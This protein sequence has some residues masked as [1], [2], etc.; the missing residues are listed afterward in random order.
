MIKIRYPIKI[1][2]KLIVIKLSSLAVTTTEGQVHLEQ[3]EEVARD[4]MTLV[5]QL[6]L[7]VILVSSGAVNAG[8]KSLKKLSSFEISNLQASSSIGQPLLMQAFQEAFSKYQ[9][10]TAQLLLTHD[11]LKSK[12]RSYNI[13]S[14][15]EALLNNDLIPIINENDAVSFDEITVGDNDQLSAMIAQIMGAD[16][17]CMLTL[18]DGVYD[19]DPSDPNAHI[20][21]TIPFDSRLEKIQTKSKSSAGRGGMKT[22]LEAVRK[23]TPLGIHVIISSYAKPSPILRAL[24]KDCGTLFLAD[25]HFSQNKKSWIL[26]RVRQNAFLII[27]HGAKDALLNNASLLPIGIKKVLGKFTRGDCVAIKFKD[28]VLAHG[29]VEY[30]QKEL[31][32]IKGLKSNEILPTLGHIH[33]KVAIHKNNLVLKKD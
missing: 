18:T 2:K 16:L 25:P 12:S 6:K 14:T 21:S 13:R 32:K 1:T 10:Q 30:S 4:I 8:K 33:S 5:S 23:L 3:I 31:E 26:T 17:L 20:L 29:I 28:Q 7:R 19:K 27:D 15:L 11:D 9:L 24:E 22:K